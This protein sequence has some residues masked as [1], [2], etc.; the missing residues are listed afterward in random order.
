[1][2]KN[3]EVNLLQGNLSRNLL[4][5][6]VPLMFL[7]LINSLYNV[8]DT[9]F[10][11]Q[12]GEL[13]VGAVSLVSPI[14]GCGNAFSA[15]LCAAGIAMIARSLGQKDREK[16]NEIATHLIA[17]CL[18]LG[19]LTGGLCILFSDQILNWLDTPAEIAADTSAY[20]L[21]ISFDFLFLFILS[22]FQAIRQS[23]GDTRT[24]VRLN[25]V[26]SLINVILDPLLIFG[27]HMG[28]LGA[29]LA[30]VLSKAIVT[31]FAL[32][33]LFNDTRSVT[34]SF[35]KYRLSVKQ[36]IN[37]IRI[38]IPASLGNFLSA[39][40]FVIMAKS[41]VSYGSVA[42]SAYGIGNKI[43]SVYYIPVN[44][45]G[46]A[47]T[48]FIGQALGANEEKTARQCYRTAMKLVAVIA[49]AVT[50]LG[51]L[52]ARFLIS[53]SIRDASAQ[54]MQLG[55]EYTYYSVFTSFFMG[56]YMNCCGVFNGSGNTSVTMFLSTFRLWGLRIPMITLF[57]LFTPLGPTGIWMSM[58]L[59]NLVICIIGHLL[60]RFYPWTAKGAHIS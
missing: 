4:T 60:Y 20:F 39:F 59:S 43:A 45:I 16:A 49:A 30:T 48:T 19:L 12:I 29:A 23:D 5:L 13:Q 32:H 9:Y 15:G 24:G 57:R 35:K 37:I 34:I 8:V 27:L 3:T 26:A 50:V 31:P 42:L 11:G 18:F 56:W 54:L 17:L 51:L 25:A 2:K 36:M 33:M 21:G 22:I 47:L 46:T 6:A 58:V 7:N 40:G 55:L 10:V 1:M 38:A 41:I 52:S 28:T 53:F 14:M 44:G